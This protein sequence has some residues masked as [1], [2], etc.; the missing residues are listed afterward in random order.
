MDTTT[1]LW[2]LDIDG[3]WTADEVGRCFSCLSELYDLRL[4]LESLRDD[5]RDMER[6]YDELMHFGPSQRWRQR[7]G[8]TGALPWMAGFGLQ[9]PIPADESH[10]ARLPALFAAEE[11]LEVRR[12]SYAS[13]G[14]AD[15]AGIGA[16]MGH[17]KDF[18]LRLIERHDGRRQRDLSD[19]RAALENDRIRLENARAFVALARDLGYSDTDIRAL[20]LHVDS[21][22]GP[23]IE[24]IDRQKLR[25][26]ST[27]EERG[28]ES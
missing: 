6:F 12:I 8:R 3:R 19:D 10:L 13:P 2:R 28:N 26:V 24:L 20:T 11:R 5:Y 1:A 16:V 4:Y 21:R 18:V 14:F 9:L 15:L 23:L 27:P 7:I 22:Q 25:S 17:L